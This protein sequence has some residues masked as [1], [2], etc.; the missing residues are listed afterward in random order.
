MNRSFRTAGLYLRRSPYQAI[1]AGLVLTITF[2]LISVFLLVTAGSA[3]VIHFFETRP[4]VTAFLKDETGTE[5]ISQLKNRMENLS[6]VK[7]TVFISKQDALNIYREQNKNDPL[8]LEMVTADILPASLEVTAADP[9]ALS[10]IASVL[11]QSPTVED[12]VYQQDVID[13]LLG[14]TGSIRIAGSVLVTLLLMS[15]MTT[16]FVIV[17]MKITGRRSEIEIMR[18]LGASR[19][20]V[21]APFLLEG[22]FYG[23]IGGLIGWGAAYTALLYSTPLI[24]R[25]FGSIP[26]LPVPFIFMLALLAGEISLGILVGLISSLFASRRFLK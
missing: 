17:S 9:L 14:W 20:Q 6:G 15:S 8:L 24:L 11:K 25:F 12:V 2:F 18:L 22:I 1:A 23:F 26:L 19:G 4:Q 3:K 5:E 21:V 10:H 16:V 13:R 7:S